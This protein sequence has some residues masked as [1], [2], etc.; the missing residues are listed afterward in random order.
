MN[1][2]QVG[3]LVISP[4]I[5]GTAILMWRQGAMGWKQVAA[6]AVAVASVAGFLFFNF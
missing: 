1:E 5:I 4:M 6:V 2:K 3:L